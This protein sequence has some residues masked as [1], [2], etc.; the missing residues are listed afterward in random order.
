MDMER[1]W[2]NIFEKV[3]VEADFSEAPQVKA[4]LEQIAIE[5]ETTPE[6][7]MRRGIKYVLV[8]AEAVKRGGELLIRSSKDG[9]LR[10]I[11]L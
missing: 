9:P 1:E 11:E 4:I 5:W 7:L 10:R 8:E 2:G 3:K 6:E